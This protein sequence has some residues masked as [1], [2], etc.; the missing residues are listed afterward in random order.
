[1]SWR[2]FVSFGRALLF[3]AAWRSSSVSRAGMDLRQRIV[4]LAQVRA[5]VVPIGSV[6]QAEF[7]DV[8]Q[9]FL[10]TAKI[11][12]GGLNLSALAVPRMCF[13]D[14]KRSVWRR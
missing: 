10:E 7:E 6:S 12:L 13:A 9:F 5:L 4:D 8:M 14:T 2:L 3:V 11:P 1:M